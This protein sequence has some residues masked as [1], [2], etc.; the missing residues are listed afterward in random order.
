MLSENV[1]K[2]LWNYKR[3]GKDLTYLIRYIMG[4]VEDE[5]YFE[6]IIISEMTALGLGFSEPEIVE[7][8]EYDFGL[9]MS[10]HPMSVLYE[11][12]T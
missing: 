11:K 5:D 1:R 4:F 7:C 12:C 8:L 10:W 6:N 3:Q 9:D 2:Q